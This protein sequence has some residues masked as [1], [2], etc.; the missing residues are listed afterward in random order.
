M[1]DLSGHLAKHMALHILAMNLLAPLLAYV[2]HR[3]RSADASL[4]LSLTAVTT[5]QLVALWSW[6]V[7]AAFASATTLP[8]M[9]ATMHMTL[10]LAALLFWRTVIDT[11]TRA[12]WQSIAALLITGK[13][14]CLLGV[15]LSFAPRPLYGSAL[16]DAVLPHHMELADQQTAGL[17][18]LIACP[19]TYVLAGILIVRQWFVSSERSRG[20]R[21]D[22]AES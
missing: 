1:V 12:P 4:N 20:W 7:P 11:A 9:G 8:V 5:L 10:F 2:W 18:M 16:R 15:L 13:L 22:R 19:L 3:S 17:L 14:F 21:F 6:H